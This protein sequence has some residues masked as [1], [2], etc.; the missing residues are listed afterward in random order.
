[1]NR[2]NIIPISA[3]IICIILAGSLI[4]AIANYNSTLN[5][6]N[7]IINSQDSTIKDLKSQLAIQDNQLKENN[8]TIAVLNS[9]IASQGSQIENL[10]SQISFLNSQAATF[11]SQTSTDKST[12][13]NLQN[14][15]TNTNTQISSLN[16]NVT[17][18]QNQVND[19]INI[20][21]L[22]KSRS[23][24]LVFH[25]CE[26][27]EGESWGHLPN[28]SATYNQI[29][30]LENNT[31]D[32]LLLP[33]YQGH[34]NWTQELAWLSANFGGSQG[35]P[36]MLDVF[37]GG[38]SSAPIP[39]LSVSDISAVMSVCNVQYIRIAEVISWHLE[40]RQPLPTGYIT[41]LFAF[42]RTQNL[43][44]FWTEWRADIFGDVQT[45]IQGYEDIVTVSFSTNSQDRE[46]L[47]GFL[48]LNG[49]FTHWGASVQA[50]YWETHYNAS[51]MDMPTSLMLEH[52]VAAKSV[53][54]EVIQFEPYWYFF[55]NGQANNNLKLLEN[56][57]I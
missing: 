21:N 11:Q 27:G 24:T 51:L 13:T 56:N 38:D 57:L 26:K 10:T 18:L 14:Q 33:E 3:A 23:P 31:Y 29:L 20:I 17:T 16:S 44:V 37:G 34:A 1:M 32:V 53:G 15:L 54:A 42:A 12:I 9:Q 6:K 30:A 5:T 25:V 43:K 19:L 35:I 40:H 50:W 2:N 46:P 49:M 41:D 22:D 45:R 39:M 52:A 7:D 55:D 8:S 28:A 47:E 36:L 4:G 48:Y